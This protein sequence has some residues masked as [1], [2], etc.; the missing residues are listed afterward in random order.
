ML[1]HAR[2]ILYKSSG[3]K[4]KKFGA[5]AF[6]WAPWYVTKQTLHKVHAEMNGCTKGFPSSKEL[7]HRR[8]RL[9]NADPFH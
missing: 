5:V 9:S 8:A 7:Y 2:R 3:I 4:L 6:F 1:D